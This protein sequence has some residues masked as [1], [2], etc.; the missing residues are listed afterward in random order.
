MRAH[1]VERWPSAR[2][3]EPVDVD[4][5]TVRMKVAEGRVKAE[6]DDVAVAAGALG[7]PLREVASRAEAAWRRAGGGDPSD[8]AAT[9]AAGDPMEAGGREASARHSD[10]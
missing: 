8:Q 1:G 7:L 5:Q 6:H 4:G 9:G 2:R 3:F 10:R